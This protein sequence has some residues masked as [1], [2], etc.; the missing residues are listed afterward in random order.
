MEITRFDKHKY[1]RELLV[2]CG[3]ISENEHFFINDKK[4]VVLHHSILSEG[5]NV[6]G[7]E[8]VVFMRSMDYIGI[9][10]YYPLSYSAEASSKDLQKGFNKILSKIKNVQQKFQKPVLFTEIGFRSVQSPWQHPHEE[11]NGR[12][13]NNRHQEQCYEV[14]CQALKDQDWCEGVFW[15]KWPAHME[16]NY[17][18]GYT[19]KG[20]PAEKVIE[21][22]FKKMQ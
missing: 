17:P 2:D 4:F 18:Q 10:C 12:N 15:W 21:K 19:P 5:I 20:K 8:A 3:K 13:A 22:W 16:Y 1:G 11:P 6:S 14:V 7:L 9:S